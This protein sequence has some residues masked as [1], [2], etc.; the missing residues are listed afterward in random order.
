M[1]TRN[2]EI[3]SLFAG[4]VLCSSCGLLLFKAGMPAFE[5]A[6]AAGRWWT[7]ASAPVFIGAA[8]YAISFLIW[9]VIASRVQLTIAYPLAIGLSLA[10]ITAGA[11]VFLGEPLSVVRVLGSLL[12]LAGIVLVVR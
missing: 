9:L 6:F 2:V 8:L 5:T 7:R 1:D 3:V 11:A 10:A 4:Y 12:I